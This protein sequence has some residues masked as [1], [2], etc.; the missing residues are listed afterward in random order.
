MCLARVEFIGNGENKDRQPLT[1]VAWIDLM[2]AGLRVVDLA[3]AVEHLAGKVRSID[4]IESV[5]RVEASK[6]SFEGT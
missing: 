5:V 6:E 1:D 4:F 3:G 2:P